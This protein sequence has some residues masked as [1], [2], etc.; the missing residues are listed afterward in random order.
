ML[1]DKK[2]FSIFIIF[3]FLLNFPLSVK[4]EAYDW[5]KTNVNE[6]WYK[7]FVTDC[8]K[9]SSPYSVQEILNQQPKVCQG[10]TE[11]IRTN[12]KISHD[13]IADQYFDDVLVES[14]KQNQ[15]QFDFWSGLSTKNS[16]A[17][18]AQIEANIKLKEQFK[19]LQKNLDSQEFNK[20]N[21]MFPSIDGHSAEEQANQAQ[22]KIV[23][24]L[25]E[26][27]YQ[28]V[29]K[30]RE[31]KFY[32]AQHPVYTADMSRTSADQVTKL[33]GELSVLENSHVFA[34]DSE[35]R[36]FMK[37]EVE[38]K[39]KDSFSV[40]KEPDLEGLKK[41]FLRDS[42]SSF[43]ANVVEQK[44]K[45]ISKEQDNYAKI[46]GRYNDNYAFKVSAV[47]SG[48]G[49]KILNDRL[50]QSPGFSRLQCELD[51]KYGE[52]EKIA[53]KANTVVIAGATL[54]FGGTALLVGRLAQ[55]GIAS[56][57]TARLIQGISS[58]VNSTLSSSELVQGVVES[59]RMPHFSK[60]DSFTCAR[61]ASMKKEGIGSQVT[62][63][64]EHSS[65][66]REMGLAAFSGLAAFKSATLAK[67]L[68]REQ[69]LVDLG[70]KDRYERIISDINKNETLNPLQ[71][72]ELATELER[73]LSLSSMESFPRDE[74]L[75]TLA[76]EDGQDLIDV[77]KQINNSVGGG[78][79]KERVKRWISTKAFTKEEAQELESC[80]V[81]T[82]AKT[83]KCSSIQNDP[84]S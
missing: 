22:K 21:T 61:V 70:I 18:T 31:L 8:R 27:A 84:Q 52:G 46:D 66:L 80:L 71:R 53:D 15:C 67:K 49:A 9:I 32:L 42:K 34:E 1:I 25:V 62:S 12:H 26:A 64:I 13:I 2:V 82:A 76:K 35:V 6:F 58:V 24:E 57:R 75:K 59:C 68:K 14:A 4:G 65:C 44:L 72:K 43:Q 60:K 40:G 23:D 37:T 48:V 69:Q 28:I 7:Q 47:Q 50:N 54:A 81:D 36:D 39:I 16:G 33:Q 73:S 10:P 17:F 5:L 11:S 79:W 83:S 56:N 55:I 77:L 20:R 45:S 29:K 51:S 74:F 63:E 3:N 38:Q 30:E 19:P 41:F 78:T